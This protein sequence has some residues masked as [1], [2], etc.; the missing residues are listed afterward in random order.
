VPFDVEPQQA[1]LDRIEAALGDQGV[2]RRQRDTNGLLRGLAGVQEVMLR[3]A[4][5]SQRQLTASDSV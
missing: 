2:E 1:S 3:T 5:L 4:R